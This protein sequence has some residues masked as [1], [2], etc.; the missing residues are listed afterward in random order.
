MLLGYGTSKSSGAWTEERR[1]VVGDRATPME[2]I[3]DS[4]S[5]GFL[6]G[7]NIAVSENPD[8]LEDIDGQAALAWIDNYCSKHPL[9]KIMDATFALTKELLKKARKNAQ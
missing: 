5:L 6:S 8:F 7:A 9:D 1:K 2:I 3:L 4:W